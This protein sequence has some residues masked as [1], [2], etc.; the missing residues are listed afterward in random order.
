MVKPREVLHIKLAHESG[1]GKMDMEGR[2][3]IKTAAISP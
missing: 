2:V 1:L 3:T